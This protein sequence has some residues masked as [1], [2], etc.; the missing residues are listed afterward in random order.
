MKDSEFILRYKEIWLGIDFSFRSMLGCSACY[1]NNICDNYLSISK[2][3]GEMPVLP[4]EDLKID[5]G[6]RRIFSKI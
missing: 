1:F 5:K 3:Q 6:G 4:C 2:I